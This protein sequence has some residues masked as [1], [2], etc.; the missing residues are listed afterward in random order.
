[1]FRQS[2]IGDPIDSIATSNPRVAYPANT[3]EESWSG[4]AKKSAAKELVIIAVIDAKAP[5]V[6]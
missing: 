3:K 4:R 6:A 2:N 5:E 1:M